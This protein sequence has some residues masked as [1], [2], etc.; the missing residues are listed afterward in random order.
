MA[1]F[2]D[3]VEAILAGAK[4][5]AKDILKDFEGAVVDDTKAF[6]NKSEEDLKRW[7]KLLAL[8]AITEQD[9]SDL[10]Q[11]RS[12]VADM[13]FLRQ[14]GVALATLERFRT[15]LISLVI[16]TTFEMFL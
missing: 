8:G 9:F 10:I 16:D 12:A 14:Q 4:D 13:H 1:K 7:T 15:R 11:A 3:F 2:D 6:L 5:I